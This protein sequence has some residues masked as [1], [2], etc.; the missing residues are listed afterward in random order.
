MHRQQENLYQL[1][2]F[3]PTSRVGPAADAFGISR[4]FSIARYIALPTKPIFF[5]K[6]RREKNSKYVDNVRK[7]CK[8]WQLSRWI[9]NNS[10]NA[11]TAMKSWT[12]PEGNSI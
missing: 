11:F 4:Y 7:P 6:K 3:H 12:D 5:L 2:R 9:I 8:T 1:Y 10:N